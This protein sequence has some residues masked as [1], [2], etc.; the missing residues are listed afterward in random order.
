MKKISA[1]IYA[2]LLV[3]WLSCQQK[4]LENTKATKT[5]QEKES[6]AELVIPSG[7]DTT[8]PSGRHNIYL[9]S[10]RAQKGIFIERTDFPAGYVGV[11]HVHNDVLYITV[12]RGNAYI[13]FGN[14]LDTTVNITPYA[15]GSFIV[16]P[17]DQP[18]Y[19]WFKEKCTLQIVG[20]GP[21]NTFYITK[22][23]E[24]K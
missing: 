16:I 20:T 12:L 15:P 3:P 9:V 7:P 21:Q 19:Q 8:L 1:L 10:S 5:N 17:A 18:H 11:P 14:V 4:A 13:A 6:I 22:S 23:T 2:I 24:E